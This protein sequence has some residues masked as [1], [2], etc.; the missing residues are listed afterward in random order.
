MRRRYAADS[1]QGPGELRHVTARISAHVGEHVRTI[2]YGLQPR[3]IRDDAR[4][5]ADVVD[6]LGCPVCGGALEEAVGALRCAAGHSFDIARQGYVNLV[7]GRAD[8]PEMVEARDAFLRAGH[9]RPLSSALAEE[10]ARGGAGSA[11]GGVVLDVGAGTGH[12][13]AAVLDALPAARGIAIDASPAALRRAAR[14]HE[15]A[16]AV[17]ADAWRPLPLRDGIATTVLSVFAPRNAEEMARALAPPASARPG[18]TLLAVTPTTR[19]LHELVGPL[20][21]LSVP[22]DKEDR[23]DAQLGS[24]FELAGRGTVEHPMFLT[25]DECA[26]LVRMGP[27]AWH[28]DETELAGGLATLPDPLTVTASTTLSRFAKAAGRG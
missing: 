14:A 2:G 12:H 11:A 26:Q 16:A 24:H 21:L 9:F 19:H 7:P 20:G 17:G 22:D 18:G 8:T 25:R 3:P 4:V 13:L 10:A 6:L 28:L 1:R 27:S 23:L 15:R 5:L